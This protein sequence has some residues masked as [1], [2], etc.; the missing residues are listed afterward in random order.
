LDWTIHVQL[1]FLQ[2]ISSRR[3]GGPRKAGYFSRDGVWL[4]S[5]YMG[6]GVPEWP[7]AVLWHRTK[8]CRRTAVQGGCR[9]HV[10]RRRL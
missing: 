10:G 9:W 2:L 8:Q 6:I 5:A 4:G 7:K 1:A 3:S